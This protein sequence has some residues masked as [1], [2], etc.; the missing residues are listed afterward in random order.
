[1]WYLRAAM[2]NPN[3]SPH[4]AIV[5]GAS[6]GI[7]EALARRLAARGTTVALLARRAE[8]LATLAKSIDSASGP[9]RARAYS[10]DAA[11]AASAEPLFA[12]IEQE[13]GEVSEM[14]FVAGIL[15]PVGKDEFDTAKDAQQF[16]VNTI[17]GV[18]WVNAAARRFSARGRGL[19]VG[20]TSVAADRG[21]IGRPAYCAT[22]A[23]LDCF[24]ESIRN[25]LWRKGVQVTTVR[26]GFIDTPMIAGQDVPTK[27]F[28]KPISADRCAELILRAAD[29]K[30]AIVYTPARWRLVMTIIKSIPSVLFRKLDV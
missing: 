4:I 16:V 15:L 25:R 1:M 21:R 10:H 7:G 2:A 5:V 20:V 3:G 23:G 8:A 30:R 19:I 27:G 17:G 11:D 26:P 14:H 12:R 22:K 6:S 29:R 24:L 9:G 28:L 13:L 18:A